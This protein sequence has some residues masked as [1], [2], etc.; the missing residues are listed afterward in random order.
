MYKL[1]ARKGAGSSAVE[2]LLAVLGVAHERVDVEKNEDGSPP[3]WFM[4]INPR[5]EIPALALPDGSVMTES[6]AMMIHLVDAHP[7]ANLAPAVGTSQRAQYLRWMVYLAAAPY[8]SDLRMYYATRYSTDPS[9]A[10]GI[11]AKAII[12]LARDFEVFDAEMGKG[13]FVLGNKISA[14]D[15]YAA[16]LLTWS[17]DV[18]ALFAKHPKLKQL[19]DSVS[20]VPAVRSVWDRNGMM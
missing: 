19:Y 1:Y 2:A 18:D 12:D 10:D 15:I 4:A 9:H 11:K 6:A 17:D 13:P 7:A 20:A 5:G 16:M 3:E 8:T 14:A